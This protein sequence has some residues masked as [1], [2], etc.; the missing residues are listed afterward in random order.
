MSLLYQAAGLPATERGGEVPRREL[1]EEAGR[2]L[3]AG[4]GL[5]LE[6]WAVLDLDERAALVAA[7]RVLAAEQA[8][9]R[10]AESDGALGVARAHADLDDGALHGNL[11]CEAAARQ[12]ARRCADG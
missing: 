11:L 6:T 4:G 2:F 10:V 5:S 1:A 3:R 9:R 12:I 8:A 7:A